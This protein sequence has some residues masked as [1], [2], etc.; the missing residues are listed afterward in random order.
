MPEKPMRKLCF[1]LI[2]LLAPVAFAQWQPTTGT[3]PISYNGGNVG[4]G[5][6]SPGYA[7]HVVG[8]IRATSSM[9][10][11]NYAPYGSTLVGTTWY[12][13]W[14]P[15]SPG[16]LKLVTTLADGEGNCYTI[17]IAG[18][19]PLAGST[20]DIR[21]SAKTDGTPAVFNSPVCESTGLDAPVE[22]G[23]ELRT[24]GTNPVAVIRIG[25]PTSSALSWK[26]SRYTLDYTG[27]VPKT[28][29]DFQWVY[30]ETT[31][32]QTGNTNNIIQLDASGQLTLNAPTATSTTLTAS[33]YSKLTGNVMVGA[34]NDPSLARLMVFAPNATTNTIG[35]ATSY[36]GI[37]LSN[38]LDATMVL[39][40]LSGGVAQITTDGT[41]RPLS[42]GS[43][44]AEAM[45]I[46]ASNR[47]GV[48]T[49][50][51]TEKLHVIGNEIVSGTLVS[52]SLSTGNISAANITASG[53]IT[54]ASVIGAV[55]Q[56]LAEW[57][58]ATVDMVPGTVVVLNREHS[59]EVMPSTHAY[60]TA[61]AGVVSAQPGLI[62]GRG[63]ASK[64]QI[65][66]TGR[67][68]VHVDATAAPIAIGDLLVSSDK[69]GTAMKSEPMQING[70]T[71][72]QP[73][74]IIGKALEPLANGEGEILVLLSLQ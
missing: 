20:F 59:N 27:L 35:T 58:P 7:L 21:C 39:R 68:K 73:G 60:D 49:S 44:F 23:T 28:A 50:S 62:L 67:V 74:T 53:T 26:F 56:D 33:G 29:A 66:T 48:G 13:P 45:R 10:L 42:F 12:S 2:L 43:N 55:Y 31:P 19:R 3:G 71:F 4:I 30:G 65:A 24:G 8:D 37:V 15:T 32:A 36:S 51:P 52:G 17:H 63:D 61:V 5:T 16:Y 38:T 57:V 34:T 69:P 6:S 47:V 64:E 54:G 46:D 72:H 14:I 9:I 40:T 1:V 22:M 41:N 11:G 25:T 70:R 18:Y